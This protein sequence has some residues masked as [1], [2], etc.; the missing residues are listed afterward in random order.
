MLK[1]NLR[2]KLVSI[3]ML[4]TCSALLVSYAVFLYG[5]SQETKQNMQ[6]SLIMLVESV[7]LNTT[8]AIV[9]DDRETT[10][11]V[12]Q[13][14]NVNK[15]ILA[16]VVYVEGKSNLFASYALESDYLP[17]LVKKHN[18]LLA[19]AEKQG[20]PHTFLE[21]GDVIYLSSAIK[22]SG[23][24]AGVLDLAVSLRSL[25]EIVLK[26]ALM[27]IS[28]IL[29]CIAFAFILARR[30]QNI[31]LQ[32]ID[33]VAGSMRS[34]S[35]NGDYSLRIKDEFHDEFGEMADSFNHMLEQIEQRDSALKV[36][37][38][39]AENANHAKSRFLATMSHEIRTP[40]NGILGMSEVLLDTTLDS[41]QKM[42]A[43]TIQRS[44]NNLL[45]IINDI[46]DFS[47]IEAGQLE[48]EESSFNLL[49]TI[50]DVIEI[51]AEQAKAKAIA[52]QCQLPDHFNHWVIGDQHRIRQVLLN[53]MGNAIKFTTEGSVTL[54][55]E[56]NSDMCWRFSVSDT[57]V[58]IPKDKQALIFD[59]FSQADSSTT[60]EY[61]GTGLGLSICKSLVLQMEGD[62]GVE[63]E[64]G[65]GSTFW[66]ELYLPLSQPAEPERGRFPNLSGQEI[67][68]CDDNIALDQYLIKL[69]TQWGA[70]CTH[71]TSV[72][73]MTEVMALYTRAF[74]LPAK[75]VGNS[76][77]YDELATLNAQI[78]MSSDDLLVLHYNGENVPSSSNL[79]HS[80]GPMI[81]QSHL[82]DVLTRRPA[83]VA[84]EHTQREASYKPAGQCNR[85]LLVEDNPINQKVALVQIQTLRPAAEIITANN[86]QE[87]LELFKQEPF[88]LVL[89]DIEMPVLDGVAA[90]QAIRAHENSNHM[91]GCVIVAL[92]ANA[93]GGDKERYLA[94]GMDDYL[95]KPFTRPELNTIFERWL[96]GGT[97]V[98]N[99]DL[100]QVLDADIECN[101]ERA[102]PQCE[103][104][105]ELNLQTIEMLRGL[106]GDNGGSL[107]DKLVKMYAPNVNAL[108]ADAEHAYEQRDFEQ[109]RN[110]VH[111]LKSSSG[112]LGV[113]SL[114]AFCAEFEQDLREERYNNLPAQIQKLATLTAVSIRTLEQQL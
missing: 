35:K 9:F 59:S 111:T 88:E 81:K 4:T 39:S 1:F 5:Y 65:Q 22:I 73:A 44:G 57:G 112:N 71:V 40:M 62:I 113:D 37:K 52:L 93:I 26:G 69:L 19:L 10:K 53:L 13:A 21:E 51:T 34:I 87:A 95:S 42:Y 74:R 90:T 70:V 17:D 85:I 48:L 67:I 77:W 30:L 61:G 25:K 29:I 97:S 45:R 114:M 49:E 7:A 98:S 79:L 6:E 105:I 27:A 103:L 41:R 54:V 18:Q 50:E 24:P 72:A 20:A 83:M 110:A 80:I 2:Q 99:A 15:D 12:L 47:K 55:L 101:Q 66:F 16:A 11:E 106:P 102:E 58:G 84:E 78:G 28:V 3:I 46:L 107:F 109:L 43:E 63:S 89:M 92:T 100:D 60:R 56:Q 86:G 32:P 91:D 96:G 108:L 68:V 33:T 36:A 14:L 75:V 76:D 82:M 23:K 31:I 38:D 104:R 94:S 8:A 64:P